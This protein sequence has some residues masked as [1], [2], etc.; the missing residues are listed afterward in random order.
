MSMNIFPSSMSV[1]HTWTWCPQSHRKV[2][3]PLELK[4]WWLGTT[5]GCWE[6]NPGTQVPSTTEP[7]L[8]H[9]SWKFCREVYVKLL[10]SASNYC[11]L[12]SVNVSVEKN[13]PIS[14]TI[15][16]LSSIMWI[17]L[18]WNQI[19]LKY[20]NNQLLCKYE[21]IST[22]FVKQDLNEVYTVWSG[23]VCQGFFDLSST[24]LFL[25][26]ARVENSIFLLCLVLLA[27]LIL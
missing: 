2:L 13:K 12:L 16:S 17:S 4:L 1:H 24:T 11:F 26:F 9:L 21:I 6:P 3:D 18:E 19:A 22:L 14:A 7:W 27:F 15:Q 20:A 5:C 23:P 10:P 8:Q 25:S